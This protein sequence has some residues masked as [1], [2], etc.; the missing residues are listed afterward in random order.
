[1]KYINKYDLS[2]EY[3]IGY[4]SKREEFWFDLEDYDKIKQYNWYITKSGYVR[5]QSHNK[6]TDMH[7]L[8][9]N[10][11]DSDIMIDHIFHKKYDNRKSQLRIVTNSQNQ[12]NKKPLLH[13]SPCTGVSWHK[14]REAW[15]A[16]IGINGKLIYLGISK[17]LEEAIKMRKAAEIKY[18][19]E[20]NYQE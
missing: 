2:G 15:I 11:S 20:Y 3:G 12:M 5:S 14:K 9:M 1:M 17:I 8:V 7:R 10:V 13:S 4:T 6:Q 19:G 18:F 16:Q